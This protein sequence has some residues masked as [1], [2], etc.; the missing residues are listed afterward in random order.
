MPP[1]GLDPARNAPE[2]VTRSLRLDDHSRDILGNRYV[3]AVLSRRAAG[4]SIGINLNTDRLCNF[5]CLY[6]QVDRTVPAG[7]H[8][9]ELD[10]LERELK[11]V[12]SGAVDPALWDRVPARFRHV[13]DVAFS[14]DGEPTSS[15]AFAEA[16]RVVRRARDAS[17]PR[18]PLRLLTNATLFHRDAVRRALPEF[19]ELWCKLDAGTDASFGL[20]DGAR[21]PLE[22]VLTNMLVIARA[23][24]IV[25]QS[26]F[27]AMHDLE[28]SQAEIRAYVGRLASLREHGGQID[29]VQITTIAR[30]PADPRVSALSDARLEAIAREVRRLG[31]RADVYG[32]PAQ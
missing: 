23:R 18:V 24:P 21:M 3:Y 7:P 32:S 20:V 19:D 4:V 1:S 5:A 13:A 25:V 26:L 8:E 31:L 30:R 16:A 2:T 27:I 10:V 14:G 17:A 15:H 29:R 28:P 6:C 11:A 9:V 22:H 12:L